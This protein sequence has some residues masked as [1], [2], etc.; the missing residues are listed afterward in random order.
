MLQTRLAGS[1]PSVFIIKKTYIEIV[2]IPCISLQ[3]MPRNK[4]T[5]ITN[6]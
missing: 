2:V 5:E 1:L 4:I 3:Q 6:P